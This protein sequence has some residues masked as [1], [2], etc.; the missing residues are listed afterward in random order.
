MDTPNNALNYKDWL[1]L[2]WK[3][4]QLHSEQRMKM[5]Q[6]YLS[7]IVVLFGSLFTL[8]S[9]EARITTAEIMVSIGIGI[10]SLVFALLDHRTSILIKD[11]ENAIKKVED[12]TFQGRDDMPLKLFMYSEHNDRERIF[13]SYSK[14]IR[15][16]EF[17]ISISGFIFAWMIYNGA[18]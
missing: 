5:V 11:A 4:F 3:Y 6:F 17:A 2:Y 9:M 10:I 8:H 16:S 15:F 14:C 18:F 12:S 7:L 13:F 1:D